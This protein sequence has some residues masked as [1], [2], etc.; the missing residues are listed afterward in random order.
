[1]GGG[2]VGLT[3]RVV[4]DGTSW[5]WPQMVGRAGDGSQVGEPWGT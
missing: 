4:L 3:L 5:N 2:E 1:M